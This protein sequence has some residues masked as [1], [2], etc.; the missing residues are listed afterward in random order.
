MRRPKSR[1]KKQ[2]PSIIL[3]SAWEATAD[4]PKPELI[5]TGIEGLDELLAGGVAKGNMV[6]LLGG[7][8][9]GKTTAGLQ[10]IYRGA[11][12]HGQPGLIVSFESSPEKLLR[13]ASSFGWSFSE[14]QRKDMIRIVYTTPSVLLQELQTGDGVLMSEIKRLKAKRVL[15][16]GVTPLRIFGEIINGRP[17]RDSLHTLLDTLKELDVTAF[18]TKELGRV[19]A[20]HSP[21]EASHEEFVC[22]TIIRLSTRMFHRNVHR[23]IEIVKSRAQAHLLGQHSMRIEAGRGVVAYRRAQSQIMVRKDISLSTKR[24]STGS[25]QLDQIMGGGVYE[26][27]VTLASG[28][29]GTG[30]TMLSLHFMAGGVAHGEPVLFVSLDEHPAQIIREAEAIGLPIKTWIKKGL[31]FFYYETPLEIEID[32]HFAKVRGLVEDL[33]IKRI[34][35]DSLAA[36]QASNPAESRD[37]LYALGTYTKAMGITSFMS[38]ESPEMLGVSQIAEEPKASSLVDNIIL[39][40]YVE[41]STRLRRALTVPKSRGS[42]NSRRTYEFTISKR[43]IEILVEGSHVEGAPQEPF[44]KYAGLLA[45]APTRLPYDSANGPDAQTQLEGYFSEH[46]KPAGKGRGRRKT[47][48]RGADRK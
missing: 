44:G 19:S 48:S 33:G 20:E 35:I 25:A 37:F 29:S 17:F 28:I 1:P 22:D 11:V 32:V 9:S 5:P 46:G 31:V 30:K 10:F 47:R 24:V 23:Y 7:P 13:D 27:S 41:I 18:L 15:I 14:L 12:D 45:R 4:Q 36:Y 16:D 40:N 2:K 21:D 26:G 6:L 34:I 42:D 38:F 8:G 39:L 43:G 3:G